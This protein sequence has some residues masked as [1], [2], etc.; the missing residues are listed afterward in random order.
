MVYGYHVH[1]CRTG[2]LSALLNFTV[3]SRRIVNSSHAFAL[4]TS[5]FLGVY[6]RRDFLG[7]RNVV[8][9]RELYLRL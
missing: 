1:L 7:H 5:V 9:L 2:C 4:A 8:I 6:N 3:M